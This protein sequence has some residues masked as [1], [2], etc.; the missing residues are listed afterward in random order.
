MFRSL[1][2]NLLKEN[3]YMTLPHLP[4]DMKNRK[5]NL[6]N[7]LNKLISHQYFQKGNSFLL[8]KTLQEFLSST[9]EVIWSSP[10]S[11]V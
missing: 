4:T 11:T 3:P 8:P 9:G 1:L 6:E 2:E 7:F 10:V 5:E